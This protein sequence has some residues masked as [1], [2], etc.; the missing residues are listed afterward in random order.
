MVEP[1]LPESSLIEVENA[2]QKLRGYK[3]PGTDQIPTELIKARGEMLC[4][5][6][7]K[8]SVVYGKGGLLQQ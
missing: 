4:P 5:D 6:I 7:H 1:L 2:I 8:L 3:S